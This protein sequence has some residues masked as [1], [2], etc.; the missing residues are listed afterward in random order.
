MFLV[1]DKL[2]KQFL[3]ANKQDQEKSF[4]PPII[5]T[6]NWHALLVGR[7]W[8]QLA[9]LR[10]RWNS[11][12]SANKFTCFRIEVKSLLFQRFVRKHTLPKDN[13][14]KLVL[15]LWF[16]LYKKTSAYAIVIAML[17][18]WCIFTMHI[19]VMAIDSLEDDIDN[20]YKVPNRSNR[21]S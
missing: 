16:C 3:L 19:I 14:K 20:K 10:R 1:N 4:A 2:W 13:P 15:P 17:W 18:Q 9:S 21:A 8:V 7:A 6:F 12:H 11:L 5:M